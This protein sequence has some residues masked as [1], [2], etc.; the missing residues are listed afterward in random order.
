MRKNHDDDGDSFDNTAAC[1]DWLAAVSC[2]EFDFTGVV[3]CSIYANLAC[4]VADYFNCLTNNTTCDEVT[5][6]PDTTGWTQCASLA[7]S[8]V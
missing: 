2:G 4:D 3:D 7:T 6:I 8:G 5:G 1:N